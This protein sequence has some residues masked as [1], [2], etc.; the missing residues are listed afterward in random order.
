MAILFR[1]LYGLANGNIGVY[2]T[3]LGEITDSTN[4]AHAFAFIGLTFGLGIMIGPAMGG[5]L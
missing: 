4:Q 2:K 5:F 1:S 3:Y